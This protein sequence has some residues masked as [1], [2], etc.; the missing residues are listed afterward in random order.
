[1]VEPN[2]DRVTE[3]FRMEYPEYAHLPSPILE[4]LKEFHVFRLGY[5]LGGTDALALAE[6]S[7]KMKGKDIVRG[8]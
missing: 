5:S 7:A 6:V 4:K 3:L 8:G 1:M 2:W